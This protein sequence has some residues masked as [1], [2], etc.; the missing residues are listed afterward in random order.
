[1]LLPGL[2]LAG[3]GIG[4]S[5]PAIAQIALGVVTPERSGMAS[6]ISNTFRIGGLAT[7]IAAL[8]AVFQHRVQTRLGTLLPGSGHG[9]A[10]VDIAG[11]PRAA[12]AQASG[13]ETHAQVIHAAT[14]AFVSGTH[15][16]LI[17]G[18]AVVAAGAVFA[19]AFVRARDLAH[20]GPRRAEV[21]AP[22][23]A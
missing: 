10:A 15:A 4:L 19:W 18:T 20:G 21:V 12:A 5:N 9:L 16:L 2:L 8:G 22:E 7:G 13:G 11:G 23:G 3:I 1:V 6:G 14:V 17:V